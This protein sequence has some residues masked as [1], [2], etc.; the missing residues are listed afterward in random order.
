MMVMVAPMRMRVNVTVTVLLIKG[1]LLRA[2]VTVC[3]LGKGYRRAE[4][5]RIAVETKFIR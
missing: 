1:A 4:I 3:M 2:F 5:Y